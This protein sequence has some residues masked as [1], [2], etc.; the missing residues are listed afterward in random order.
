[1][2][3]VCNHLHFRSEDPDTA[4]KFYCD[5]F[6][7]TIGSV[8][9]LSTT[10]SI[11][12]ELNGQPLMTI[13]GRAEGENPRCRLHRAPLR[14][15]PLRFHRRRLGHRRRRDEDPRR[16]L[17]LRPLD[18]ALR[19]TRSLHRSPRPRQHRADPEAVTQLEVPHMATG[20]AQ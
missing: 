5:N 20:G 2:E 6:G 18:H 16:H 13:S 9:P 8:N 11:R 19:R 14:S 3:F 7:A 15:R 1:M 17:H 12:L 4:A 10:K